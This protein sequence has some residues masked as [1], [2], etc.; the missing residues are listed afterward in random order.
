[1]WRVNRKLFNSVARMIFFKHLPWVLLNFNT[2]FRLPIDI[3]CALTVKIMQGKDINW[4]FIDKVHFQLKDVTSSNVLSLFSWQFKLSICLKSTQR[5][6]NLCCLIRQAVSLLQIPGSLAGPL[7]FF[8]VSPHEHASHPMA[9][10]GFLYWKK[11]FFSHIPCIWLCW[12]YLWNGPQV[13]P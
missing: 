13:C 2:K 12:W 6:L 3:T 4:T 7:T 1:M 5:R 9:K 11:A 10:L 8:Q